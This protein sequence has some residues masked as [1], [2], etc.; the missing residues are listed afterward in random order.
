M[1]IKVGEHQYRGRVDTRMQ[2]T[3]WDGRESKA[4][5]VQLEYQQAVDLFPTDVKW[6]IITETVDENEEPQ[7][8]IS[9]MSEYAISGP[10]TDNRDGT[11]TIRMGK[12]REEEL[13][14]IPLCEAPT[15][16]SQA[17]LWR[18]IIESAVQSIEHDDDAL[19]VRALYPVWERLIGTEAITGERFQHNGNLYK[20]INA[21]T[22]APEWIPGIG[23]ESLYMRIDETHTGTEDDPIPY[24]GNMALE[25][26]LYYTQNDKL[27]LCNRDT[28][29]PVYATLDELTGLYV[30][31]I[32]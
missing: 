26:G 32:V 16:H 22:Y 25:S 13:M 24:G 1:I 21:H 18:D 2:D 31:V 7:T 17:R 3:A 9:D 12:Y 4:I 20:V 8:T 19:A 29:N 30:E 6:S 28:I 11:V 5:T 14:K 10:I 23:T 15:T 27:Y